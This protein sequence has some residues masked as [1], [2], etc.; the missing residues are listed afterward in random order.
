MRRIMFRRRT[1]ND[2][3]YFGGLDTSFTFSRVV[4]PAGASMCTVVWGWG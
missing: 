1:C 2:A 3:R 4:L